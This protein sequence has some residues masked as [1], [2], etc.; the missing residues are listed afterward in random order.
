[1]SQQ[2]P[3]RP[4]IPADMTD[5]N[6]KLVEEFRAHKGQLTGPMA[7]RQIL[8][9]TTKGVRTGEPRTVVIGYRM[10]GDEI[11]VIASNNGAEGDPKWYRNLLADP[12]A[13]VEVG[14]KKLEVRARV[15]LGDERE[16][17]GKVIEYLERQ[18]ALTQRQIPV[19]VLEQVK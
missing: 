1:M 3:Q 14:D 5:F 6:R 16:E 12:Q 7:G 10:A 11:V 8:L 17:K 2:Q 9:L 18:Q 13:T 19:L 15:T 4:Q